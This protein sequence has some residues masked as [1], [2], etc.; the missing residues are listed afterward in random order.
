MDIKKGDILFVYG[1]D[2]ISDLIEDITHGCSHGAICIGDGKIIE[3]MGFKDVGYN[4]LSAYSSYRIY[5]LPNT[6]E[7]IN[8][9]V[10]WLLQQFGRSYDYYD[11]LVLCVRC[12]FKLK[13]PW[14]EGKR[15]ICSRLVRDYIAQTKLNIPDVNMT[16]QDVQDWVIANGGV[17]IAD[18]VTKTTGGQTS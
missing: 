2:I 18:T 16:P 8:T 9:G 6:E 5:R 14:K 17:L 15:L 1:N 12:L 7:N 11:I 13:L 4:N 10:Q 3:A